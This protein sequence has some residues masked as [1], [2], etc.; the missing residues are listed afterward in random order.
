MLVVPKIIFLS[1]SC[2][3]NHTFTVDGPCDGVQKSCLILFLGV[4]RQDVQEIQNTAF[5]KLNLKYKDEF[6]SYK[7]I[8]GYR[9]FEPSRGME[10][11][12]DLE[13]QGNNRQSSPQRKRVHLLRPLG[14]VEI[15]PM[16]Y[17]TENSVVH[18][19]LPLYDDDL[20]DFSNFMDGFAKAVLDTSDNSYLYVVFVNNINSLKTMRD[21]FAKPKQIIDHHL[22]NHPT[23]KG[24]VTWKVLQT[25]SSDKS[26]ISVI[27]FISRDL[28]SSDLVSLCTVAM[29]MNIDY[30]NRVR[31]NTI[32]NVQVFFP[33]SFWQYKQ[34]IVYKT[35]PYPP[36]VELGQTYGHFDT[37]SYEHSSFY[38][39]DF[40]HARRHIQPSDVLKLQLVDL[41]LKSQKLHIFRGAEPSLRVRWHLLQCEGRN[42][43]DG[44]AQCDARRSESLASRSQL[45]KHVFNYVEKNKIS[46]ESLIERA[47]QK[48]GD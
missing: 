44:Q 25:T 12:L 27:D 34:S 8:N 45:A 22:N 4:D 18:L 41:L 36:G 13:L 7:L 40:I 20:A 10:Y 47:K 15:V 37:H 28:Q 38:M 30:L 35:K 1:L 16:P 29:E 24:T 23:R 6:K 19:V 26:E 32:Q 48:D 9:K 14:K 42:S 31:M 21:P 11:T 46:I 17:V 39:S 33:I 43:S 5:E 3:V 2:I